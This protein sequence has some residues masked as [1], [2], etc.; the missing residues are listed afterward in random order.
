MQIHKYK[1]RLYDSIPFKKLKE[2]VWR[3]PAPAAGHHGPN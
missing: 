2:Y 1:K 3:A